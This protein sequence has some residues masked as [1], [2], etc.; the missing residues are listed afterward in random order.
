[1]GL[2]DNKSIID[3]NIDAKDNKIREIGVVKP[4]DKEVIGA[5]INKVIKV[6]VNKGIEAII[7]NNISKEVVN[8]KK[9]MFS[10]FDD[11]RDED[12]RKSNK[13]IAE[14]NKSSSEVGVD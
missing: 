14:D 5:V 8:N 11:S 10:A 1:L 9:K 7:N 6:A 13:D 12:Y 3:T 4:K 2:R